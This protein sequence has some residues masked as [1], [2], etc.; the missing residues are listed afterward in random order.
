MA[1]R[2]QAGP[3]HPPVR[4]GS[5]LLVALVLLVGPAGWPAFAAQPTSSTSSPPSASPT[6]SVSSSSASSA[7]LGPSAW[8]P[9][10]VDMSALPPNPPPGPPPGVT[11][12]Q[13]T[14]C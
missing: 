5:V 4:A 10:A 7:Q 11:Y 6:S 12:T 3:R 8:E 1:H 14:D 2:R 13:Q 9:P